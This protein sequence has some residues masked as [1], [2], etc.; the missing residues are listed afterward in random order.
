VPMAIAYRMNP[1]T[2]A[3]LRRMVRVDTVTLVNLVSETRA[4][5]EF[6]GRDCRPPAIVATLAGLLRPGPA[7]DAQLAAMRLTMERLGRGGPDPGLRAA[8]AVLGALA[9]GAPAP[10]LTYRK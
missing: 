4:V 2:E 7:R 5:P 6:I 8:R 10:A 9:G 1:L 3:V